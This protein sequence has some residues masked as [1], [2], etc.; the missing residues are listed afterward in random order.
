MPRIRAMVLAIFLRPA[1]P[2]RLATLQIDELQR[3]RARPTMMDT[4]SMA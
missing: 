3:E 4:A 2:G 1:L